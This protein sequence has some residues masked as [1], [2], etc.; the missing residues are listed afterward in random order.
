MNLRHVI[1]LIAGLAASLPTFSVRGESE[2]QDLSLD[3]WR[4]LPVLHNGRVMPMDSYARNM[5]LSFSGK[6]TFERK[7]AAL[8][9]A[10]ALFDPG[11][12]RDDAV[13]LINHPEVAEALGIEA[14]GRHRYSFAQLEPALGELT[15]LARAAFHLEADARSAV[16][17]EIMQLYN[18]LGSYSR[19]TQGFDFAVPQPDFAIQDPDVRAQLDLPENGNPT[20]ADL[21][22]RMSVIEEL[23]KT[24]ANREE[25]TSLSMTMRMWS[26]QRGDLPPELILVTGRDGQP[27]WAGAWD[28]IK[29]AGQNPDVA[30]EIEA[31]NA[32]GHAFR[33]GDQVAFD[34]AA[35]SYM[36]SLGGRLNDPVLLGKIRS[37]VRYN[38]SDA[39]YRSELLYGLAFIAALL[40]VPLRGRWMYRIAAVLLLL[41]LV[42]HT[43]G[44]LARMHIMGRPPVTNLYSTFV[45]VSWTCAV[46]G[47]AVEYFQRNRLGLITGGAMGLALLMTAARFGAEGD[48]MGVMVAVLDSNFWLATHV[49]TIS[50][51]YAGCC[52]SA[53]LGHIYLLQALRRT[54]DDPALKETDRA[55]YG[56]QAFG[57][58]F[59]YLGTMLGGVWADQ[60]WGRFWGWDPKENGALVIVLW[61][62]VLFHARLGRMIGPR[63]FAA[64]SVVGMIAVLCAWIGV[65]LLGVGLHSYGFTSGLARGLAITSAVEI[66]FVLAT[67]PFSRKAVLRTE[68]PADARNVVADR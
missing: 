42:P 55:V 31:L 2:G 38:Q 11:S 5:L 52:A 49:V 60:S 14:E 4:Q 50:I 58:I 48:T 30:R 46:I 1:L 53:L 62:A 23:M 35:R 28:A 57:L 16:E 18:N 6:S 29:S 10:R 44:M 65:N 56:A 45:F 20:Y 8:W 43:Y 54:P 7:P 9:M 3:V 68:P 63:G 47:L 67:L 34:L 59:T 12:T 19:L 17:T 61:S 39:F 37:E 26:R 13:F 22:Q 27:R 24:H 15:R 21:R 66:L 41:A 51:G 40:S 33:T 64:G 25:I 32:M 36:A